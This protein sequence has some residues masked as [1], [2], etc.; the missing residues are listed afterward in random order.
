MVMPVWRRYLFVGL[1]ASAICVVLPLGVVRDQVYCLIGFYGVAGILLGVRENQP[2]R[3]RGWYLFAAGTLMWVLGDELYGWYQHVVLIAPF[4][5]PADALYLSAY[6]LFATGLLVLVRARGR[7]QGPSALIDTA[8][9]TVALALPAWLFL[10]APAWTGNGEHVLTRLVSVA[11]PF[12]DMMLFAMLT[13][14]ATSIGTQNTA[15]RLVAGSVGALV[16]ADSAFAVATFVPAFADHTYLLDYL[17]LAS[18]V[19]WGAAAIHPSMRRLSTPAPGR[20]ERISTTRIAAL[21]AAVS[22]GPAIIVGEL[23]AG[24]QVHNVA[25]VVSAGMLVPLILVRI[26]RIVR[27]LENQAVRL[28]RLA[29]TDYVTGLV[30]RRYFSA[31]LADLLGVA[32]PKATGILLV[33]LER[34]AEINDTLGQRTADAILHGV[35]AR[36]AD[37]TGE[38]AVVARMGDDVY[39][40]LDPSITTGEEASQAATRIRQAFESPLA[41][42]GL[43][44]SIEVSV[45]AVVVPEDG[46]EADL[47]LLRADVALSVARARSERT[48]RY[49]KEMDTGA[50]LAPQLLTELLNAIK[51]GEIVVHYQPQVE[52]RSGRVLGVEALVRWQHPRHGLLGPDSFIPAV[53]QTGLIGPLTQFVLDSALWQCARWRREGLFLEIAVNLS[54]R[55]LLDPGIVDTVRSALDRHGLEAGSLELEIT[56]TTAMVDPRRSIA[57]LN[58]LA[59][60]GVE[61][62]IDD[63]GTGQSSLAYLQQLP[64]TRL[65]IDRSFVA[66]MIDNR[67]SA[68]IVASTIEL[69]RVLELDV[70]A[71]GVED[72]E[73]LLRL[74]DLRCPSVQGFALG[75]PV[76]ATLLPELIRR[77]E[78]RL[79][80]VLRRSGVR[81][82][83]R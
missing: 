48:A 33:D 32:D 45:G 25:I 3:P 6:V 28:E 23:I 49:G 47:A 46:T 27:Q 29:D 17:W 15:F 55:N 71:E 16:V 31:R 42:P 13:W 54:V 78:E 7:G 62:S 11:Y 51:Q 50:A 81:E 83:I 67:A 14:L 39:G 56:E 59:G 30:N 63:Y 69:A 82:N 53:E 79:P 19:L 65:K 66:G 4:P 34:F 9:F 8:I 36:L 12:G 58:A 74:R 35:G 72:D 41:L 73:T 60:L 26:V 44:V 76:E 1:V 70:V 38:H 75:P 64:V 20:V 10:I 68:A 80:P 37:L 57:V 24:V 77:I 40:V 43:S 22:V 5:S 61:L 2:A 21:A 18:Y 52:I